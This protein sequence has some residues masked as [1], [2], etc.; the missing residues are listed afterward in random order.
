[1]EAALTDGRLLQTPWD[2]VPGITEILHA[3]RIAYLVLHQDTAP[4]QIDVGI[5]SL[6]YYPTHLITDGNHRLGAAFYRGDETIMVEFCGELE[7]IEAFLRGEYNEQH[8]VP[9]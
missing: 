8:L 3:E 4:I 6:G 7:V 2:T 5:P 9:D 1:M